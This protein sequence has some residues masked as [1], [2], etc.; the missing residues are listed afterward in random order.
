MEWIRA[1][2]YVSVLA[3]AVVVILAGAALVESRAPVAV[4]QDTITWSGGAAIPAY[5][6]AQVA[7]T[8]SPQQIAQDVIQP[9]A[10]AT[11]S[12]PPLSTSTSGVSTQSS[13]SFNYMQ[14][15]AQLSAPS[16]PAASASQQSSAS[17]TINEAYQFIPTGLV[18][19]TAPATE[20]M[21]ADQ[22]AL[23][24]YG[25]EVGGEIQSFEE[26]NTDEAQV[27]K[28]QAEDRT[29][30]AKN[31][32]VVS[33]GQGLASIGTYM[34]QMQTVPAPVQPLHDALAQSYI[35]IG[36]ELQLVPQAQTD[37]QFVQAVENY[38]SA[39]N[40]FVQNYAA[41]AQFF[42]EQGV[43]FSQGDPGSVFSFTDTSGAGG[44]L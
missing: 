38:D 37:A 4:S 30:P 10:P 24:N 36:N 40:T 13:G 21:T 2:P 34:Q 28:D 26:L 14:L 3:A 5:Q 35:D 12:L 27:L 32:A 31:A 43:T 41:L 6:N 23:Y 8:P 44:G 15:L 7:Q 42:S 22:Q 16:Q 25:N 17:A 11:L 9:Q 18:A 39:A 20:P 29:N 19:T 1:H 33:L